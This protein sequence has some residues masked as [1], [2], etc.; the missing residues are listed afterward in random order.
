MIVDHIGHS[1]G[2]VHS[3]GSTINYELW[4]DPMVKTHGKYGGS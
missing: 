3:H 4:D 1:H 2:G